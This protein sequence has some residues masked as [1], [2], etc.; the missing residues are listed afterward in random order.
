MWICKSNIGWCPLWILV[1]WPT[2]VFKY[3]RYS[4]ISFLALQNTEVVTRAVTFS[5]RLVLFFEHLLPLLMAV[6]LSSVLGVLLNMKTTNAQ[7]INELA[8]SNQWDTKH[9]H[10]SSITSRIVLQHQRASN[11]FRLN[12]YCSNKYPREVERSDEY[13]INCPASS[14]WWRSGGKC[15]KAT[16]PLCTVRV[17]W[18]GRH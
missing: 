9:T 11:V 13:D 2:A 5:I 14:H 15:L 8:S 3:K 16:P 17:I 10:T 12:R 18:Y 7:H 4:E 1:C 6:L